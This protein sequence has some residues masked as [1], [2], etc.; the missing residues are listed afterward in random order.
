MSWLVL[1]GP[2]HLEPRGE[3]MCSLEMVVRGDIQLKVVI[4]Y[5]GP[6]DWA[7]SGFEVKYHR[8]VNT[9]HFL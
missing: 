3:M 5:L 6:E 7:F 9:F 1:L 8:G 2:A 4:F